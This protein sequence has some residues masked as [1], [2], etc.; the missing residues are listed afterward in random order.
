VEIEVTETVLLGNDDSILGELHQL[1]GI[2]V[3]IALDDFGTGYSSLSYLRLFPFD[4]IKIDR[5]FV[6][7]IDSSPHCAAIVCALAGL[8]RS[9]GVSTTAEGVETEEQ[10]TLLSA[11]G[12]TTVQGYLFGRPRPLAEIDLTAD[13]DGPKRRL[14]A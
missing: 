12:C 10:M 5:S 6:R 13:Q 7:D 1:R 4:R 11:A 2:D 3:R 9:L 8:A 14:T